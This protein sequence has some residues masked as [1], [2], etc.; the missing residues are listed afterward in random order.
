M[1]S[2]TTLDM[3]GGLIDSKINLFNSTRVFSVYKSITSKSMKKYQTIKTHTLVEPCNPAQKQFVKSI[4]N[5]SNII[6]IALGCPGTGKTLLALQTAIHLYNNPHYDIERIIYVRPNV[7]VYE[8]EKTGTLPG[9]LIEKLWHLCYPLLDNLP[10]IVSEA[11]AR[12]LIET[13]TIEISNVAD[14]RGR[15]FS[16]SVLILDECQNATYK[17]LKTAL[18]RIGENTKCIMIG[19]PEQSDLSKRHLIRSTVN[20]NKVYDEDAPIEKEDVQYGL[21]YDDFD[22]ENGYDDDEYY[23]YE[24]DHLNTFDVVIDD[25][26]QRESISTLYTPIEIITDKLQSV[27]GI[28]V[29]KFTKE[30]IVRSS[31]IQHILDNL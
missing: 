7:P 26:E 9:G 24:Q 15:S 13:E 18:T 1:K 3:I 29:I 2:M 19:D 23:Y 10:N 4:K 12:S 28:K 20:F 17:G 8:E 6:T 21:K 16:N 25:V 14:L 22:A 27:D 11:D 31:I 5:K 30:D